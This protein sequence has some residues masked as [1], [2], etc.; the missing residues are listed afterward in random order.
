M[1]TAIN[2]P[3]PDLV[4]PLFVIFGHPGTLTLIP[5]NS[6]TLSR[7]VTEILSVKHLRVMTLNV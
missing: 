5:D 1:R 2:H 6:N 3:V 7:I 4:K